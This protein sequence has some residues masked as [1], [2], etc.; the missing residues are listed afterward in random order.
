[1][2]G[3]KPYQ[4]DTPA[5]VIWMQASEP[6][7]RP[8]QFAPD[9]PE[10]VEK[11]LL[12]ALAKKPE[13]RYQSMGEFAAVLEGLTAVSTIATTKESAPKRERPPKPEKTAAA[14]PGVNWKRWIPIAVLIIILFIGLVLGGGLIGLGTKGLGPLAGLAT[15][16]PT[17]TP[18][19]TPTLTTTPTKTPT[20][21]RTPTPLP[22]EDICM[23]IK[24]DD[25]NLLINGGFEIGRITP[26]FWNRDLFRSEN[27]NL[28]WDSAIKH[29]GNYSVKI[30]LTTA[31]DC[32]WIQQVNLQPDTM[33]ILS[34]WVKTENVA[35]SPQLSDIGANLSLFGSGYSSAFVSNGL[36]GTNDWKYIELKFRTGSVTQLNI[37]ARLGYFS[38]ITSGTAWFDDLELTLANR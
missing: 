1:V 2:T 31:N 38:G 12:K 17:P 25:N 24:K 11:A 32:R 33:Y 15:D 14:M 3:R 23:S 26:C 9:L 13:D 20:S 34:G 21:T 30:V 36:L 29:S 5:A 22:T 10:A 35:H 6:L 7:P 19:S 28:V 8:K 18:T 4:A 27:A 37:A 16:T